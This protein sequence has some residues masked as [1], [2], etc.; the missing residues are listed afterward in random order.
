M[1]HLT[2]IEVAQFKATFNYFNHTF[3]TF[4]FNFAI[5]MD[6]IELT[7]VSTLKIVEMSV[8]EMFDVQRKLRGTDGLDEWIILKLYYANGAQS[9]M[10]FDH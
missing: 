2:P 7:V 6:H 10:S 3:G 1:N 8:R 9:F 4:R 5:P